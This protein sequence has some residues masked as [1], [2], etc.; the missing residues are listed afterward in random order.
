MKRWLFGAVLSLTA[1]CNTTISAREYGRSCAAD[2]ECVA[3]SDGELCSPCGGGCFNAAINVTDKAK[4]DRDA[5]AI[6]NA[7]PPRFGPQV[8]CDTASCVRTEAFCKAGSCDLR[9]VQP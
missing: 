5:T 6:R 4:F 8:L 2:T 1:G 3:V 9:P 7:C